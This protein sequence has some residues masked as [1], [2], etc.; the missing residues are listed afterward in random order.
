MQV[1]AENVSGLNGRRSARPRTHALFPESW[2]GSTPTTS[3]PLS[4]SVL[5]SDPSPLPTSSK[6]PQLG[7]SRAWAAWLSRVFR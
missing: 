2:N 6:R 5:K 4:A 7:P 3:H 1:R